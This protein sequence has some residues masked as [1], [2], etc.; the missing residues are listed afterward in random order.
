[1]TFLVFMTMWRKWCSTWESF[2]G[3]EHQASVQ[4][5]Q[6]GGRLHGSPPW[7][8]ERWWGCWQGSWASPPSC[9]PAGWRWPS[10][11]RRCPL[12]ARTG[13]C[14]L[15][16]G[17]IMILLM[18]DTYV[19]GIWFQLICWWEIQERNS[20]KS[21]L[22]LPNLHLL[23]IALDKDRD[24]S[25]ILNVNDIPGFQDEWNNILRCNLL[26]EPSN[27]VVTRQ[28][29]A[30]RH[31]SNLSKALSENWAIQKSSL[32]R[33]FCKKHVFL[34]HKTS[35]FS[36]LPY[37]LKNLTV[38]VLLIFSFESVLIHMWRPLCQSFQTT[39]DPWDIICRCT[40]HIM[41]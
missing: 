17:F 35:F 41:L 34:N 38:R 24:R 23:G 11:C 28:T 30:L 20:L 25:D 22:I 10:A 13:R 18:F 15:T 33:T 5:G 2:P 40:I 21:S 3:Q 16:P 19:Q 7:W 4:G 32:L 39:V 26:F 6:R 29:A 12:C 36:F 8:R 9:P 27:G 1:M 31:F 14:C 37:S